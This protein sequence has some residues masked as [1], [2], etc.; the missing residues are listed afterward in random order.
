MMSCHDEIG[1]SMQPDDPR[2]KQIIMHEYT[3]FA[4]DSPTAWIKMR[5]PINA[6]GDLGINWYEASKD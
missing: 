1:C 2:T 4:M 3:D 6:S 5:V